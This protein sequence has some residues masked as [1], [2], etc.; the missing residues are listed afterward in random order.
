[1]SD[2]TFLGEGRRSQSGS[3][4][5]SYGIDLLYRTLGDAAPGFLWLVD[6]KGHFVYVNK[7]WEDY[8]GA[9]L[10]QLNDGGW[11][12]FNHPAELAEVQH[13]WLQAQERLEQFEM[14]L[15]YRRHDGEYR[16]MLSRVVPLLS[17]AG[18]LQGWVG[19]TVD[20]QALKEAQEALRSQ[21]QELSEFFENAAVPIHWVGPDGSILRV[22]QAELDLLGYRREEYVGRN[23]AEFH[24]DQSVIEDIL[25]RLTT[26]EVL[27]DYPA[28]LRCKDG[29]TKEVL[30]DSSGYFHQGAFVHTRCFTRDVTN[31]RIAEQATERLAA[32]V[33]S[34]AD[35]IVSKTLTGVVTSWNAAAER[36]F[37][38]SSE[39]MIG[40]SIYR[41]IPEEL[42]D[43]ERSLL[44]QIRQGQWVEFSE[45]ERVR[46][47]GRRITIALSVSPIRNAAGQV[48][49]ASSIKRDIT[50]RKQA[51]LALAQ[52]QERLQLALRAARMGTWYWDFSTDSMSWDRGLSQLYGL[53]EEESV[54]RFDQFIERVHPDD[55]DYV[56]EAIQRARDI[57]GSLTIE[58]RI[59]LS[60]GKVRWLSDHGHVARDPSGTPRY[61]T[62]VSLDVTER[63]LM[64]ERLRQAQRM[65]SVG[66]L[67]GGIA[68]EANNMMSV[69]L[70]CADYVLQRADLPQEVRQDVDQIWRAAKRTAGITQQLLAFS[71]R[72][73]L[74]P[75]ILDLN[76]TVRELEPILTRALGENRA[77][78][79]HLSP[80]LGRVRAD[81]GQLEQV[82]INLTLNA[83]DAMDA[84]GRLTFETMN[85]V[86]DQAYAAAKPVETL[87]PGEFAA[88]I[89]TDTG[90]GM[91]RATLSHIFEP[92]FT[93]KPVGQGTGLGLST[94]Y[95]IVKQSGGFIWAYSEAGLGTTFK[96]YFP[97]VASVEERVPEDAERPAGRAEEVVLIAED[98][99]MV[100]GI[101]A[102][103]LRECGYTILEAGDGREALR[104]LEAESRRVSLI[105]ADVVMPDM[106]GRELAAG[107]AQHWPDVPVLFTSGYTGLDVV[108]RGLLEEGREFV[109]K[110]LA[111][112]T[113]AR[114]VR[115]LVDAKTSVT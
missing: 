49:G 95:G 98:E 111:P 87:E 103:T 30:I 6:A 45:T 69:V 31:Q 89:V 100:R 71:R 29:S 20:I 96:L 77:I 35:A 65:D 17:A 86:L 34:S 40:A 68:H 28:R 63:T 62:G 43:A 57:T 11:G 10:K 15:R 23:I 60:N 76:N 72:Q 88:L 97:L 46:K 93:T 19:T 102:R 1:M 13:R 18:E 55:R 99:P 107:V 108:R 59:L 90:H 50:E 22:N 74:R 36:I 83:R 51:E 14:E 66:Q 9:T 112:E 33:S 8:T 16:W 4:G 44:E 32:I 104:L 64:E 7:T 26:G 81:P 91:D 61:M 84:G 41:L 38:Y 109:Q 5:I 37:G 58:F 92:F 75:Q 113:L 48:V 79:M 85:V 42:H 80:T 3:A 24:V 21:E 73:M 56:R 27:H 67:A 54:I 94:V 47:D 106:G 82:L 110:P 12:Q 70:G 101:M 2:A 105:I 78:R 114:K 25:H 39:E 115:E 52:S 53:S